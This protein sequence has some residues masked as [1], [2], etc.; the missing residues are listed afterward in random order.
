M[1]FKAKAKDCQLLVK[2]E[3][4]DV[5]ADVKDY[6]SGIS[7]ADNFKFPTDITSTIASLV[8]RFL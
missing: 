3:C 7:R 2:D 5:A 6:I 8:A 4:E 1:K